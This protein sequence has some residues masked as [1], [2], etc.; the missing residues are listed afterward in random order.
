MILL[1][2]LDIAAKGLIEGERIARLSTYTLLAIGLVE[3]L[4]GRFSDSIGMTADGVTSL[5][6][7]SISFVIWI[8]LR[9]SRRAPDNRFHFGYLKVES[10]SALIASFVMIII[11]SML[12]YFSYL[13]FLEP[14]ELSSPAVALV[15]LLIAGT[16]SLYLAF[17]MRGVANKYALLSL[18]TGALNSIKDGSA[19]FVVFAAL[20]VA[21]LG[22]PQMDAIGGMIIAGYV[23]SVAYVSIKET[24]LVLMDACQCPGGLVEEVKGIVESKYAVQVEEVRMRK[25]GPYLLGIIDIAADGN[26]TLNQIGELKENIKKDLIGRIDGLG[27]LSIVFH[28]QKDPNDD[29]TED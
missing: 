14:K 19:S 22:F 28:P 12:F 26:L 9:F 8:G 13:R 27:E 6:D 1:A 25:A 3:I 23:Y 29:K 10:F 16:I 21:S 17:Q 18:R 20:L 24:S 15:T 2:K 7:T 5:A 4:I 11:G